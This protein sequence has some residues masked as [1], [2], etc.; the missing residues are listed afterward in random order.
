MWQGGLNFK[1]CGWRSIRLVSKFHHGWK[2]FYLKK[3]NPEA[4]MAMQEILQA[5]SIRNTM[6]LL[7]KWSHQLMGMEDFSYLLRELGDKGEW[8][9][10]LQSFDWMV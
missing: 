10:M 5:P 7:D 4:N 1:F 8:E 9:C 6:L 2:K 3:H